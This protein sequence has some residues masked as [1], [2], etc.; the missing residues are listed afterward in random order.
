[1]LSQH[2]NPEK[3]ALDDDI[4]YTLGIISLVL[5]LLKPNK[6]RPVNFIT[7]VFFFHSKLRP[8]RSHSR[9]LW[10]Y[11]YLGPLLLF[12]CLDYFFLFCDYN[13]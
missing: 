7:L 4:I 9:L 13:R 3:Y 10:A 1:M 8:V 5:T 6:K 2:L 12:Q 11:V